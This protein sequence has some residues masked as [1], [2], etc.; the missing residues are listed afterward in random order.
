M[1]AENVHVAATQTYNAHE[2]E[3]FL[4]E[5]HVIAGNGITY[6]QVVKVKALSM[7]ISSM[8]DEQLA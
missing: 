4:A 3:T 6:L 8:A 7:I 2:E 5:W 1:I